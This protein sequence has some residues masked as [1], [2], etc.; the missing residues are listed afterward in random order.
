MGMI[1]IPLYIL[2]ILAVALVVI[3]VQRFVSTRKSITITLITIGILLPTYDIIITNALGAYYCKA[4]PNP[5]TFIKEKVEYPESIYWEDNIFGGFDVNERRQMIQNYLDGIHLKTMALNGEDGKIYVYNCEIDKK[6]YDE[7]LEKKKLNNISLERMKQERR[8]LSEQMSDLVM[9][10]KVIT[11]TQQEMDN[12]SRDKNEHER[13]LSLRDI[14][15]KKEHRDQLGRIWGKYV[16]YTPQIRKIKSEIEAMQLQIIDK[17]SNKLYKQYFGNFTDECKTSEKVYTRQTMPQMNYT[18][19]FD[20]V[21]LN[22]FARKFLYSDETKVVNNKTDEIIAYNRRYMHFFYNIAP[23]FAVGNRYYSSWAWE[24][25]GW[26]YG[27]TQYFF[28]HV[29]KKI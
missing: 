25:C 27:N 26:N 21:K 8:K 13:L 10:E 6:L 22:F 12:L 9:Q 20:E 1:L 4:D 29:F 3:L 15:L 16:V 5:K 24:T 17:A 7:Y 11:L 18:V 2:Y 23:D 19:T 28:K 14:W